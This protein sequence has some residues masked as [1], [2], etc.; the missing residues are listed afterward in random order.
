[1]INTPI[2]KHKNRTRRSSKTLPEKNK[3]GNLKIQSLLLL[4]EQFILINGNYLTD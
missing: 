3:V 4:Q 2:A 1:M